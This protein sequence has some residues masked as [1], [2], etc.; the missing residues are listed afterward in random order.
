MI[1]DAP[2]SRMLYLC[3]AISMVRFEAFIEPRPT[4]VKLA[5][6]AVLGLEFSELMFLFP[7]QP[8]T[9]WTSRWPIRGS[10]PSL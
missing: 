5:C 10:Y 2:L 6:L 1:L 3:Y 7:T 4:H 9:Q 8:K